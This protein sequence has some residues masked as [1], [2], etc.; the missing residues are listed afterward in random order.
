MWQG[1]RQRGA[2]QLQDVA[3]RCLQG[4]P[5]PLETQDTG[6]GLETMVVRGDFRFEGPGIGEMSALE[7]GI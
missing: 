5:A 3:P 6:I 7:L 1:L 4:V 2:W